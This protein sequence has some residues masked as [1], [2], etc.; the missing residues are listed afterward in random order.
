M[1]QAITN[2]LEPRRIRGERREVEGRLESLTKRE[3]EVFDLVVEGL[4]NKQIA[5]R[6]GAAE[7]TVKV[8]RGRVMAKM[9]ANSVAKL[10]QMAELVKPRPTS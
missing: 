5:S 6:L 3:R 2:D 10:V 9:Q 7:K 1:E 4:L 8:H